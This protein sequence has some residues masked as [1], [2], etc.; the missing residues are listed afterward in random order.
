MEYG[1]SIEID[2]AY[3]EAVPKVKEAFKE[4]G[5][6]T[7]T[8]I[9]VRKNT[10]REDRPRHRALH[11]PRDMQPTTRKQAL[12]VEREIGLLLPCN[13]VVREQGGKTLIQALDPHVIVS[14]PALG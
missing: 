9:D 4:Q 8:E 6:G 7:L 3:E 1:Q 12:D 13:V 10:Q 5:F 14:V 2:L 11:D